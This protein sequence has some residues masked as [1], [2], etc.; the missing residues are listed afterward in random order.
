VQLFTGNNYLRQHESLVYGT[1]AECRL[2]LE[3]EETSFQVLVEQPLQTNEKLL[4]RG[5]FEDLV[6][7]DVDEIVNE[8]DDADEADDTVE[9]KDAFWLRDW[10]SSAGRRTAAPS[11]AVTFYVVSS[12]SY[13]TLTI[14]STYIINFPF[15]NINILIDQYQAFGFFARFNFMYALI[16]RIFSCWRKYWVR[17]IDRYA[18]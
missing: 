2:C 8:E 14:S 11:L 10:T 12:A 7:Q 13:S 5:E 16:L 3:D 1:E 6:N 15:I 17:G 9:K 18:F 4:S